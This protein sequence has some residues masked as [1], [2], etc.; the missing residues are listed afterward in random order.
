MPKLNIVSGKKMIKILK[1]LGFKKI[2]SKG[3]HHFFYNEQT[4]NS[5]VVP[6]HG[7]EDLGKGIL[8]QILQ[9]IELN[10]ELLWFR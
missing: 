9:N 7:N 8:K 10:V 2:R 3:S 4:N 5:T 1:I 6:I